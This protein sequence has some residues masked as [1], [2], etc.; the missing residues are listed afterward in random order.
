MKKCPECGKILDDDSNFCTRCQADL[1]EKSTSKFT[2]KTLIILVIAVIVIVGVIFA[3]GIFSGSNDSNL[4][5]N[6]NSSNVEKV[7]PTT[8]NNDS[9]SSGSSSSSDTVYWAS[10]KAEKFHNPSCEWAQKIKDSNKIVY[11]S[12]EDAIEDGKI[13]CGECNP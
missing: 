9:D 11:Q 10:A 12:R 1:T 2:N 3:S 5:G 6:D 7:E 13:P 4:S 8:N